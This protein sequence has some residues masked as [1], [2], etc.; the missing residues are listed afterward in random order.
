VVTVD[1][2]S[3]RDALPMAQQ[4][5]GSSTGSGAALRCSGLALREARRLG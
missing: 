3:T 4:P 5:T 1:P 2:D